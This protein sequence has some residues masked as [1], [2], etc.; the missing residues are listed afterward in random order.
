MHVSSFHSKD[1]IRFKVSSG[2]AKATGH[3]RSWKGEKWVLE[4]CNR[5]HTGSEELKYLFMQG[6][7]PW[8][9]KKAVIFSATTSIRA[10]QSVWWGRWSGAEGAEG[11]QSWQGQHTEHH[12][13]L[14]LPPTAAYTPLLQVRSC[15]S[16][17]DVQYNYAGRFLNCFSSSANIVHAQAALHLLSHV[18]L[19]F[20]E[21][22]SLFLPTQ[23]SA[24]LVLVV[25]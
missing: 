24:L 20:L 8:V 15:I 10:Y 22:F 19:Q 13:M 6:L 17:L 1:A 5:I 21:D 18:L 11:Q 2:P 3:N 9:H 14:D 12:A 7:A 23:H 4:S 25:L 16:N